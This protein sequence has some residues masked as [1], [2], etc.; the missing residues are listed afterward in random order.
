[1]LNRIAIG[2]CIALVVASASAQVPDRASLSEK[3]SV[4]IYPN[5][6]L[7]WDANMELTIDTFITL[8][9]DYGQPVRVTMYYVTEQCADR[10][11][12]FDLT[13]EQPSYW[14][15]F[16]GAPGPNGNPIQSFANV[17]APV[18]V[19]GDGYFLRGYAIVIAVDDNGHQINWN[20]L[21]GEAT[22]VNYQ[23]GAAYEY[24]AYAFKASGVLT[25]AQVGATAGEIT[26]DGTAGVGYSSAFERLLCNYFVP[27]S[28]VYNTAG[29]GYNP[30]LVLGTEL[31]LMMLEID[32]RQIPDGPWN[33]YA[34]FD[35]YDENE[36][37]YTGLA[38]CMPKFYHEFIN[39]INSTLIVPTTAG[40]FRV[41]GEEND[42]CDVLEQQFPGGPIDTVVESIDSA[43][44]GIQ[45]EAI[46]FVNTEHYAAVGTAL[47]GSGEMTATIKWTPTVNG[48]GDDKANEVQN[49]T[50]VNGP[51]PVGAVNK[52]R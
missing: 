38:F 14:S 36:N 28:L 45:A 16:S 8:T 1:M 37:N 2:L 43:L 29:V 7:G 20:K 21:F 3:G 26:L 42:A 35:V 12:H 31:T 22:V 44:L 33:T 11:F 39:N 23:L 40:Y 51:R 41:W 48:G 15:A 27:G 13:R 9:N 5:I 46:Q 19:P 18:P 6:Q 30:G 32:L 34:I 47:R 49:L 52:V 24:P 50:P 4:L 10:D 25:G 17:A